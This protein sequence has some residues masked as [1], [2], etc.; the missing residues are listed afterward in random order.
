MA[1]FLSALPGLSAGSDLLQVLLPPR[2]AGSRLRVLLVSFGRQSLLLSLPHPEAS[3]VHVRGPKTQCLDFFSFYCCPQILKAINTV[4]MPMS[5]SNCRTV[6]LS[7]LVNCN[8]IFFNPIN[9]NLPF[10]H[11]PQLNVQ[12]ERI[13]EEK[14]TYQWR[15]KKAIQRYGWTIKH[16]SELKGR[17]GHML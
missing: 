15:R 5:P 3:K 2:S 16:C 1:S 4:S 13:T 9:L 17:Q 14:M 6:E 7:T 11:V 12:N 10:C 8:S